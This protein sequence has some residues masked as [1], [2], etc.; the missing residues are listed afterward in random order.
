MP[1]TLMNIEKVPPI[2][3]ET[4]TRIVPPARPI[5]VAI[6]MWSVPGDYIIRLWHFS[7]SG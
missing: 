7:I 3:I 4:S 1:G 5:I 2:R 6:S